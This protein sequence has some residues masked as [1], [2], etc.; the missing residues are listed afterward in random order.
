MKIL[1]ML[2]IPKQIKI[3][4]LKGK[5]KEQE[6]RKSKKQKL[7][8]L[9]N[10]ML[11]VT[12]FSGIFYF[13]YVYNTRQAKIMTGITLGILLAFYCVV[14]VFKNS[15]NKTTGDKI[16]KISLIDED[17]KTVKTWEITGSSAMLIGKRT[18][19]NN[20]DI[21]LSEATYSSLISREHAIMNYAGN[22][23]YFEDIGSSNGSGLMT[24][25]EA[26]KFKVEEGKAYKLSCGDSIYI[27]NTKLV[28][29]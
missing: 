4:M 18:N 14:L 21:D 6:V 28:I 19:T 10:I 8:L 27:A 26:R 24:K 20:V 15:R 22:D 23:W 17:N 1:Q 5:L 13:N 25:E 16:T 9:V 2:N 29:E 7:K 3:L 11:F 12:A